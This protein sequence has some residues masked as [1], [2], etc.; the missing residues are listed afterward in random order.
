MWSGY[1]VTSLA[2]GLIRDCWRNMGL[3]AYKLMMTNVSNLNMFSSNWSN[4][5]VRELYRSNNFG[6]TVR[7][8]LLFIELHEWRPKSNTCNKLWMVISCRS[9][10]HCIFPSVQNEG[11][12]SILDINQLRGEYMFIARLSENNHPRTR[13]ESSLVR[14]SPITLP[15]ASLDEQTALFQWLSQDLSP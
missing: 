2:H 1:L 13:P 9:F 15:S 5:P 7:H 6:S 11:T 3:K 12:P 4:P 10:Y 8:E 14:A